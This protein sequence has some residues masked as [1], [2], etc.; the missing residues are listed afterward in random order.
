M[1][2]FLSLMAV[3]AML[4]GTVAPAFADQPNNAG[5]GAGNSGPGDKNS[6]GH[7]KGGVGPGPG[8]D[9]CEGAAPDDTDCAG[10]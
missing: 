8:P 5:G 1:K 4:G 6:P 9:K 2:R 10:G 3:V 7:G